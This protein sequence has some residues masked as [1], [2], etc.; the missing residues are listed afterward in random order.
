M[1]ED[2]ARKRYYDFIR[3]RAQGVIAT[4]SLDGNPEAALVDIAVKPDLSIVFETTNQTRKFANLLVHPSI[5]LVVGWGGSETLQYDGT[6]ELLS[7]HARHEA[8]AHYLSVFPDKASH[9]TWPG[10]HYFLVRPLWIRFSDY[11]TPRRIEEHSFAADNAAAV[12]RSWWQ[13]LIG[14]TPGRQHN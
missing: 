11:D 13:K 6:A 1:D 7:N 8:V 14:A 12:P 2:A 5:A 9:P 3:A 10:N 4:V